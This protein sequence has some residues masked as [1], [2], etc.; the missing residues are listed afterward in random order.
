[1]QA[2]E[3]VDETGFQQVGELAALLVGEAG[4][5]AVGARV[6]EVDLLVRHVEVSA[7]HHGLRRS[8]LAGLRERQL[9]DAH[10]AL[11]GRRALHRHVGG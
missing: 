2:A 8:R 11:A 10:V 9:A 7:H 6:L 5:A 4:L 1:M 3:R